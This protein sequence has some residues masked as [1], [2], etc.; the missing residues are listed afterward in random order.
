MVQYVYLA[1]KSDIRVYPCSCTN[2]DRLGFMGR[3]KI[4]LGQCQIRKLLIG[5]WSEHN[6]TTGRLGPLLSD[7]HVRTTHPEGAR[8]TLRKK[9]SCPA[10]C[11][12]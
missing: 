8:G 7:R 11:V 3:L 5:F 2:R 10:Q 12:C 1:Q 9:T 4:F 6:F